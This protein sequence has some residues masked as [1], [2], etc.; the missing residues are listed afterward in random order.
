MRAYFSGVPLW[1]LPFVAVVVLVDAA[2]ARCTRRD[3]FGTRF[4]PRGRRRSR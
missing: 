4:A 2:R 3:A 1:V